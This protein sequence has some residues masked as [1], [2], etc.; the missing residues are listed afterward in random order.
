MGR[1]TSHL[2]RKPEGRCQ[3]LPVPVPA[4]LRQVLPAPVPAF[5]RQVLPVPVLALLRQ[6]LRPV[7]PDLPVRK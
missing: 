5:L 1:K 6:V 4:F 7:F 3:V 2:L